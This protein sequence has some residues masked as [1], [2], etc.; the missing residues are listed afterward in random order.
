MIQL[1]F[2]CATG[3]QIWRILYDSKMAPDFRCVSTPA[4]LFQTSLFKLP[5]KV[6]GVLNCFFVV[7]NVTNGF[8]YGLLV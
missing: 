1:I 8:S 4:G 6:D 2:L 3:V 5:F 7:K